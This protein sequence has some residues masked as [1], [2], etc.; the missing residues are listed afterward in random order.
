MTADELATQCMNQ[1]RNDPQPG[2]K[3]G[4]RDRPHRNVTGRFMGYDAGCRSSQMQPY[5]IYTTEHRV[6][7]RV[8][9]RWLRESGAGPE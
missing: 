9:K 4:G 8:W 3:A 7:L 2:M 1:L 5:V 6:P